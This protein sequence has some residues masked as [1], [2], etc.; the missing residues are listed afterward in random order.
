MQGAMP[1]AGN[2]PLRPRKVCKDYTA[3]AALS[4]KSRWDRTDGKNGGCWILDAGYR[5]DAAT[6]GRG[7]GGTRGRG[8][9]ETGRNGTKNIQYPTLNFQ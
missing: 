4:S 1:L 3:L 2:A 8:E 6:R 9:G 5:R 7:E